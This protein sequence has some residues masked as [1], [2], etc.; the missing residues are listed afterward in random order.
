[1]SNTFKGTQGPWKLIGGWDNKGEGCFPS[2]IF[3][4]SVDRFR[5]SYGRTGITINS[6][7]DQKSESLMAN[8]QLIAHAPEM[9]E[10]LEDLVY[11]FEHDESNMDDQQYEAICK[12]KDLITRA[13]T[14]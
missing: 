8:A 7:H 14:I 11:W 6:S 4:G 12:A 9:L 5:N 13:I 10:M 1:M 2:V 3:H